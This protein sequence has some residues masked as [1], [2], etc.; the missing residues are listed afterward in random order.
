MTTSVDI[1]F[2]G[3][4]EPRNPEGIP[5][6][7]FLIYD[8]DTRKLL[9]QEAGL[10]GEPRRRDST[11]NLAEY[12]AAING[13][14]WVKEHHLEVQ[15]VLYGDAKLVIHQLDGSY[16]VRSERMIPLHAELTSLLE[17]LRWKAVWVKREENEGADK[18]ANEFYNDYCIKRYG[19]LMPTMRDR[20]AIGD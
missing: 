19:K 14:K 20:G 7:A 10:A 9:A 5:V 17:G 1:Y 8:S 2:D 16:K 12:K 18:L 3:L 4:C 15:I 11:H 13:V 6:Y